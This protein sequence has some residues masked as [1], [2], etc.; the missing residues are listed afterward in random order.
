MQIL[1]SLSTNWLNVLVAV[2][3]FLYTYFVL[4]R[5]IK[6][7]EEESKKIESERNKFFK[8]FLEGLKAGAISTVDDVD[9]IYKGVRGSSSEDLS[10]RYNLS[11]WLKEFLVKL[12]SKEMDESIDN[13][14]LV[15]W[16]KK[17]S[18]FIHKIE[19]ASPYSGLPEIERNILTDMSSYLKN[20]NKD[21]IERKISEVAGI[22][23]A[24]NDDLNKIRNT[25]KWAVPL[26]VVGMILTVV[27]GLLSILK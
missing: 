8:A 23:Q 22:L 19:E 10:Y 16:N 26:A 17:I 27:F 12:I 6:G 13:N 1:E 14:V 9:N 15:E 25:N 18:D 2:T 3:T 4:V 5:L 7:K 21:G 11:K 24:R 20:D